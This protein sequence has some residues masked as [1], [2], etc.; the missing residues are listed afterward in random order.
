MR[1]QLVLVPSGRLACPSSFVHNR[2]PS[3][4][5]HESGASRLLQWLATGS[6]RC[7][8]PANTSGKGRQSVACMLG[9]PVRM[10]ATNSSPTCRGDTTL[11]LWIRKSTM[12]RGD[13]DREL[14]AGL[15]CSC[16]M[17][18]LNPAGRARERGSTAS[19]SAS[20]AP[21][22]IL[23]FGKLDLQEAR[24]EKHL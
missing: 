1:P 2:S 4:I 5:I 20:S 14:H 10:Q 24:R 19:A 11:F 6:L 12:C 22:P 23:H 9:R 21:K 17:P 8:D 7:R 3:R 16:R 15:R 18:D 13:L